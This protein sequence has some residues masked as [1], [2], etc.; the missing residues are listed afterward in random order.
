MVFPFIAAMA[1]WNRTAVP[2]MEGEETV[3]MEEREESMTGER[4]RE[5]ETERN[6]EGY[7]DGEKW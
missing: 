6:E 3:C 1:D 7:E 4:E 5:K 2:M